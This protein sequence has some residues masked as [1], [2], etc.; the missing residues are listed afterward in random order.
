[1]RGFDG[2]VALTATRG[3]RYD[4]LSRNDH[5]TEI[6]ELAA[7]FF[8]RPLRVQVQAGDAVSGAPAA[9]TPAKPSAAEMTSAALAPPT[10]QS[11]VAILGG[12]VAEVRERKPRRRE[13]E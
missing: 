6:E 2:G 1:M 10:V 4:Y 3:F 8:G 12:E 13:A 7:T 9:D 11:A 5:Q